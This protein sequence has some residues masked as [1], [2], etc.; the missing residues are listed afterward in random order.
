LGSTPEPYGQP[1]L[2]RSIRRAM[3][4]ASGER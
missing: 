4:G 3:G 1:T 2:G